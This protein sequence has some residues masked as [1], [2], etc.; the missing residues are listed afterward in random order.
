MLLILTTNKK[1]QYRQNCFSQIL[2]A[3]QVRAQKLQPQ[4][5]FLPSSCKLDISSKNTSFLQ[6]TSSSMHIS[7]KPNKY[8]WCHIHPLAIL[9]IQNSKLG[10]DILTNTLWARVIRSGWTQKKKQRWTPQIKII[11]C[12]RMSIDPLEPNC[13]WYHEDFYNLCIDMCLSMNIKIE[14]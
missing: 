13:S 11:T 10:L 4:L 8:F 6:A 9:T 7:D 3:T 2:P 1:T 14:Q 5:P 12:G